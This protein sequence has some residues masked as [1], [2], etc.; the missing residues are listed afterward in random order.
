[1]KPPILD[2]ALHRIPENGLQRSQSPA[3]LPALCRIFVNVVAE[4]YP[5]LKSSQ[6]F[7]ELRTEIAGT[8]NRLA[9]ARKDFN[10]AVTSFK[11]STQTFPNNL[12][13]SMFSIQAKDLLLVSP[14]VKN[15]PD[16]PDN[17]LK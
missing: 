13:A 6:A 11:N 15:K 10:D 17:F 9:V 1:M 7:S 5:E 14:E 2:L 3:E 8:E 16:V 4:Q 12:L